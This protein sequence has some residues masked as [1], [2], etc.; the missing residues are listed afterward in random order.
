MLALAKKV[1]K[2]TAHRLVYEVA[3]RAHQTEDGRSLKQAL[4][5]SAAVREHLSEDAIESLL[6]YRAN[7]GMCRELVDRVLNLSQVER[8]D[9]G[10]G[11]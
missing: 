4:L 9:E 3:M 7:T 2:Q 8:D 6:D 11:R 10:Q 5:E 1:G